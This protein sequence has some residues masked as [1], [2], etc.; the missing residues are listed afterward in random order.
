MTIYTSADRIP[1][2]S[3][4]IHDRIRERVAELGLNPSSASQKA[5]LS[6]D[7]LRKLLSNPDQ[8]PTGKTLTGLAKALEVSEQWILTGSE[9]SSPSRPDVRAAS[10]EM[11]L[12]H[13]MP[14]DV[15]VLGT[16]AGSHLRGAFQIS[17]DPVDYVRRPPSLM[18]ARNIYS[19]YVEGSSMEP[20]YNPGDLIYVHPD[21]PPR[22]GDAVV[23]QCQLTSEGQME[24]TL[25]IYM[26]RTAEALIIKKHNPQ[27]EVEISRGIIISMHKVLTTNE[28]FGV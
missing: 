3:Q 24:A 12:R 19:L 28:I 5:G 8:M 23:V 6:K 15:P 4:T 18:N 17:S 21:R 2:M 9:A 1:H 16:A 22:P 27:A 10:S 7:A 26:R 14:N 20:Q 11:P 25:G 13:Q